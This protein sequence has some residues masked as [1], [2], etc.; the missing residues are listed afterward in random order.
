MGKYLT[1]SIL[2]VTSS[3]S[4][5]L[6]SSGLSFWSIKCIRMRGGGGAQ[7]VGGRQDRERGTVLDMQKTC[8][9]S[10]GRSGWAGGR[11]AVITLVRLGYIASWLSIMVR[12][13]HTFCSTP[14][15]FMY[16]ITIL[17]VIQASSNT[18]T[19]IIVIVP[20][21]ILSLFLIYTFLEFEENECVYIYFCLH[22]FLVHEDRN[23][24]ET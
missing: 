1:L 21:I 12:K 11:E 17:S 20:W 19:V 15:Y 4:T 23:G 22:I 8:P 3:L 7:W 2:V 10:A 18:R 16:I 14:L 24:K 5:S 9:I 6:S 13:V